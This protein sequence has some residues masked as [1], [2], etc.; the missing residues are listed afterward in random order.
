[1]KHLVKIFVKLRFAAFLTSASVFVS[2]AP[3]GEIWL[4]GNTSAAANDQIM[5]VRQQPPSFGYLRL[6]TQSLAYPDLAVFVKKQGVPDFLAE[7]H[8]R[9]RH[10]FILYYL[11]ERKAFACRS[12][13]GNRGAVE[14]A[15]P[16]PITRREFQLLDGFRCGQE[17]SRKETNGRRVL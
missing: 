8:N 16:Y 13:S 1:M 15:G 9:A 10:Y 6:G 2:C 11:N 5:L 4:R 7:T 12:R 14:F 3:I 17:L